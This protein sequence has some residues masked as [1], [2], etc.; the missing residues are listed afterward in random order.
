MSI[1][2]DEACKIAERFAL[3]FY[4]GSLKLSGASFV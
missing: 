2:K 4:K 1:S 3:Q